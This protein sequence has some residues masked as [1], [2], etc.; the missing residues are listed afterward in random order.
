MEKRKLGKTGESLSI[1]GF[2]G[3]AVSKETPE[4]SASTE[5]AVTLDTGGIGSRVKNDQI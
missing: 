4:Y 1:V 2:G 5:D 3:I